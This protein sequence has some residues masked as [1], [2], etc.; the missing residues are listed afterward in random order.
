[1][2]L[3]RQQEAILSGSSG[4][5]AQRFMRLLERLGTIY[6]AEEMVP[7]E[8]SQIAGV[9]YKS[10]GDAGLEFLEDLASKGANVVIPSFLNPAGIDIG[11]WKDLGISETFAE[12]QI[13]IIEA[14]KKMG[15]ECSMTCAPYASGNLLHFGQ[16]LAWSESSA[17]SFANSVIG[18]MTNREGGPSSLAAA[19]CGFT[20]RYGLHLE[21]NRCPS[22]L[23]GVSAELKNEAD[24]GALGYAVGK[25]AKKGIPYFRGIKA[26]ETDCLKALGAAMAASGAVAL[27]HVENLTPE[28]SRYT[29][30]KM[31]DSISFGSEELEDVKKTINSGKEPDIV[32]IGCPH[33]S[34]A[35]IRDIS[36]M[37]KGKELKKPL[38]VCS[39]R[40]TRMAAENMGYEKTIRDAGG[41]IVCDTCMVVAPIEDLPFR[42]VGINSGKA[43]C[44]LPSLCGKDI[45]FGSTKELIGMIS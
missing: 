8:S 9:S 16:H 27:Y 11:A 33:S 40:A 37:L 30:E 7:A 23:V 24:F 19:V 34:I 44:Y 12:K 39:S 2:Y 29:G 17:V 43:A 36:S 10:I 26:T 15:I 45:V 5:V 4:E 22:I 28:A 41:R 31:S 3:T 13:R 38:W 20:P 42:T 6:G 14:F 35:E 32:M 18:A 21:E 25:A 1:M